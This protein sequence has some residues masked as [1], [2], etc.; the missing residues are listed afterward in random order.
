ME[1]VLGPEMARHTTHIYRIKQLTCNTELIL[2]GLQEELL[3]LMKECL[4]IGLP[5]V[6]R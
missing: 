5:D 6:R 3:R 1:L 2:P 4:F